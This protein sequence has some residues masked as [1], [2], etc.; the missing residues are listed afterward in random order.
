MG[1]CYN[2]SIRSIFSCCS[3]ITNKVKSVW[4]GEENNEAD[5]FYAVA[6]YEEESGK[7]QIC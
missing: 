1:N 3:K 2:H 4:K 5:D 6:A 7:F